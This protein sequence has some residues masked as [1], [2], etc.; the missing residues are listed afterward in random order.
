VVQVLL[1]Y[2]RERR[3]IRHLHSDP[4]WRAMFPYLPNQSG[5]HKRLKNAEPLL[6][7]AILA[8]A[9]CCPSWFDDLWMT[10]ATPVPCGMSR[11]TATAPSQAC[12]PASPNACRPWPQPSGTTGQPT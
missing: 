1:G 10:D 3:W 11:E 7:T 5:Y 4:Q 6:R 8:L 2:Y 9:V 12:T